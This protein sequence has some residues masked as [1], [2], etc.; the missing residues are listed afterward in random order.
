LS[1]ASY[2][3]RLCA[4]EYFVLVLL[5]LLEF[6]RDVR[7]L[8]LGTNLAGMEADKGTFYF[9]AS[10]PGKKREWE[11]ILERWE[12]T[13]GQLPYCASSSRG[14]SELE[15]QGAETVSDTVNLP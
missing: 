5:L 15:R 8:E 3:A 7:G 14:L 1:R 13:Q 10:F 4:D 12:V 9:I 6:I 11:S 2:A